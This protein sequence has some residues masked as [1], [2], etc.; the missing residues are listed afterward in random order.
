MNARNAITALALSLV[1]A[2]RLH[3]A[4]EAID[5]PALAKKS[6]PSVLLLSVLDA[7]GKEIAEGTGFI[8]SSDGRVVTNHHVIEG[9][10]AMV[11]K[12]I[13]GAFY[14]VAGVL[15][16]NADNDIAIL[17]LDATDLPSLPLGDSTKAEVGQPIAVIGSPLGLEGTLSEGIIS[18]IREEDDKRTLQIS[19]PISPGS[20]GSPV[21]NASGEVIGV[22]TA[23]LTNGQA[24]NLAV[25]IEVAKSLLLRLSAKPVAFSAQSTKQ[26]TQD[27][28]NAAIIDDPDYGAFY[29]AVGADNLPKALKLANALVDRY[30]A[31]DYALDLQVE[32]LHELGFYSDAITSYQAEIKLKPDDE[33]L[34][35]GLAGE[36]SMNGQWTDAVNAAKTAIK[37]NPEDA[38]A[39]LWL[40]DAQ[41]ELLDYTDAITALECAVKLKP[42]DPTWWRSL[43]DTYQQA[44]MP[45]KATEAETAEARAR[46]ARARAVAAQPASTSGTDEKATAQPVIQGRVYTGVAHAVDL[47]GINNFVAT[48]MGLTQKGDL[49]DLLGCYASKEPLII[50][51]GRRAVK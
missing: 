9:A 19:A 50:A 32:M 11:A 46:A 31:S 43:A 25:P 6:S 22:A 5:L 38:V 3:A 28:P 29:D 2:L 16:Q 34:W 36:F 51:S 15:A 20:S 10:S 24:L 37:L 47:D 7:D 42:D 18:A 27:D 41:R 48:V 40:G 44:G 23:F 26:T 49:Y 39:W 8:I 21:L 33:D 30:P 35:S 14:N 45:E 13:H 1:L 12:G 17:K 4:P